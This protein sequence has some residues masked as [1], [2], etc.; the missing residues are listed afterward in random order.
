[1]DNPTSLPSLSY[2]A[3]YCD[4]LVHIKKLRPLSIAAYTS[5]IS[6][7]MAWIESKRVHVLDVDYGVLR[8]FVRIKSMQNETN[9]S[10]NRYISSLRGLFMFL[11]REGFVAENPTVLLKSFKKNKHLPMLLE[12]KH[13]DM[14]LQFPIHSFLDLRDQVLF[15]FLY[16]TGCRISEAL[17]IDAIEMTSGSGVKQN[18]SI[19][20]KGGKRRVVFFTSILQ[21]K[22]VGYLEK[23]QA[24]LAEKK[25]EEAAL[26]VNYRGG[27][28]SR[29][30]AANR[31]NKRLRDNGMLESFPHAIRHCFATDLL[32]NGLDIRLVQEMLG[33][34]SIASTQ[35][36]THLS[37][38]KLLEDYKK[39]HPRA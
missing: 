19:M 37:R 36:Y 24:F 34:A 3:L 9:V 13:L 33:H 29:V 16:A 32:D 31:L 22:M 12:K 28:L 1:M 38:K 21:E 11:T 27:R 23:R 7:F 4:E 10:I 25:M 17:S 2:L 39:T 15:E 20:G 18:I 26:F 5:D 30:G 8:Q 6:M 14:L 35:I